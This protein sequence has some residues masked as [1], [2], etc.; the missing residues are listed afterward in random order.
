MCVYIYI[1]VHKQ[2]ELVRQETPVFALCIHGLMGYPIR[3]I[4]CT[5][6][7]PHSLVNLGATFCKIYWMDKIWP[8]VWNINFIFPSIGNFIIP[9][10]FH[11]F[12]RGSNHQPDVH[13]KVFHMIIG[14]FLRTVRSRQRKLQWIF[15]SP[16]WKIHQHL[17]WD[18]ILLRDIVVWFLKRGIPQSPWVLILS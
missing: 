6:G 18:M 15:V 2:F 7:D 9:I 1:Y 5:V 17:T 3:F 10:D 4:N 14:Q 13:P 12:Q 16:G 11:I 8:A